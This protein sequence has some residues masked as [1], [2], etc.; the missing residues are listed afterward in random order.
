[1]CPRRPTTAVAPRSGGVAD[2]TRDR[3][4]VQAVPPRGPEAVPEGRALLHREVR[5][6]APLLPAR[7]A[8]ARSHAPVRVPH[9]AAREAEG[10]A[11]LP[12]AR[13]AVPQLLPA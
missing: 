3:P 9:P 8:R 7:R 12:G 1:M 10:A 5:R 13:E 6:R 11:L 2:G 4:P